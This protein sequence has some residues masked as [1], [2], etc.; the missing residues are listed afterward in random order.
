MTIAL[1][2]GAKRIRSLRRAG[3]ALIAKASPTLCCFLPDK[4]SVRHLLENAGAKFARAGEQLVIWGNSAE[5]LTKQCAVKTEHLLV[6]N[7]FRKAKESIAEPLEHVMNLLLPPASSEGE[8]CCF[9]AVSDDLHGDWLEAEVISRGYR[10]VA[11]SAGLALALAELVREQFTGIAMVFGGSRS[12]AAFVRDGRQVFRC[13][14][15]RGGEAIDQSI[16]ISEDRYWWSMS[17]FRE[18]E[19]DSIIQ[20]KE[21]LGRAIIEP[22]APREERLL[23]G[24]HQLVGELTALCETTF[25]PAELPDRLAVVAGGGATRLAGFGQI[26]RR[27]L[28]ESTLPFD[29]ETM[30]I[31]SAESTIPRG[32]LIYAELKQR[33]LPRRR[34]A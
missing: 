15:P 3:S 33:G 1:D 5:D 24:Y 19:T 20:W 4:P 18:L 13:E 26:M 17:G 8:I 16:A 34:A 11:C 30:R 10:A 31:E 32:L 14:L 28:A 23:N 7:P 12:E 21:S 22:E 25:P 27:H 2:V 29:L 9:A 6:R